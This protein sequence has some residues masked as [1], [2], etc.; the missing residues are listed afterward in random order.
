MKCVIGEMGFPENEREGRRKKLGIEREMGGRER[1]KT[2]NGG[3]KDGSRSEI[4]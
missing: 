4:K 3:R 1:E 2:R